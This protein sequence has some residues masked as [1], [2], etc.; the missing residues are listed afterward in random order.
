MH[1]AVAGRSRDCAAFLAD[2]PSSAEGYLLEH[3]ANSSLHDV[4]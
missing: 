1:A 2:E 3:A 4:A